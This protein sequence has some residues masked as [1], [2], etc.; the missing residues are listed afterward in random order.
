MKKESLTCI[1]IGILGI[2]FA[3]LLLCIEATASEAP[4]STEHIIILTVSD[5]DQDRIV[6]YHKAS[7]SFLLY[8]HTATKDSPLQ[9]LQI[10]RLSN[11]FSLAGQIEDLDYSRK[12]YSSK[13][14]VELLD[15][16]QRLGKE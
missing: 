9:L 12:G 2:L 14:V 5:G 16:L 10:R 1:S 7:R 13:R 15:N 3:S 6:V 8:G 4:V 11:D